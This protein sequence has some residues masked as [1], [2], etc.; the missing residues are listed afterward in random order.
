MTRKKFGFLSPKARR[1]ISRKVVEKFEVKTTGINQI[2]SGLSGGNRQKINLGRWMVQNKDILFLDSPTR[3]VDVGVK[4]YIYAEMNFLKSSG[5]SII[6][7]SDE[8]T[9]LIGM[10][11]TLIVMKSGKMMKTLKRSQGFS[12]EEIIEVML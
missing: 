9:E 2:M 12:D 10:C 1:E 7:V 11:D 4:S 5:T 8:L 3:G 6:V